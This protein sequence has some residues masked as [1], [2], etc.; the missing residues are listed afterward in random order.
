MIRDEAEE[1]FC[2]IPPPT[3][4]RSTESRRFRPV[5]SMS[6]Y[7]NAAAGCLARGNVRMTDGRFVPV[8]S[9]CPG[10]TLQLG[11]STVKVSCVV[12][13]ECDNEVEELVE[14]EGG[15]L[16]TP[17]HPIRKK[18][19]MKW[20]FPVNLGIV[21]LYS[22]KVVYNFVLDSD[23]AVPIGPYEAI[24]LGHGIS[25]D[26]VA[27]HSYFGSSK[28]IQDLQLMYGWAQGRVHLGTN[29][30]RRDPETGQVSGFVQN[31]HVLQNK[32]A[33]DSE[34]QML[35]SDPVPT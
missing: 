2:K 22:C 31:I 27:N 33:K 1:I 17:W 4:S 34:I 25:S 9:V 15:V 16:V 30:G 14:L 21:K 11:S 5:A 23:F 3:P 24:T 35:L 29:P 19:S 26:P 10:D 32:G 28:I 12:T 8:S 6:T 20:E 18:G 13:T 7:Y